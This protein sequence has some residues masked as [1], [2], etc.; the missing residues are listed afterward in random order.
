MI[1]LRKIN[2]RFRG[3]AQPALD[4]VSLE[5]ARGSCC[6]LLGANGAGKTTLILAL[7]GLTPIDSGAI[8]I[9][10]QCLTAR[11]GPRRFW[12]G[13]G[14]SFKQ[15]IGRIGDGFRRP[16]GQQSAGAPLPLLTTI[17]FV[18]QTAAF[19]PT[20]S[21]AENLAFF[22]G[23]RGLRGDERRCEIAR[24][25]AIADLETRLKQRAGTLSGGLQ[26]RLNLAIGLLGR[27]QI[28]CL[29][30]PTVGVDPQSREWL[31][32][33]VEQMIDEGTTVL[34][35]SHYMD[36][37]ARLAHQLVILEQGRVLAAGPYEALLSRLPRRLE[38]HFHAPLPAARLTQLACELG[39][40][41]KLPQQ[42]EWSG[43]LSGEQLRRLGEALVRER[44]LPE[45][46]RL[47]Y[48]T[49]DLSALYFSLTGQGDSAPP[50]ATASA[51]PPTPNRVTAK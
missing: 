25:V 7:L 10:G 47:R 31:L 43:P 27:P 26:R 5:I 33:S 51:S 17:G 19:Y 45:I 18:P 13:L 49:D 50:A 22:A 28:L 11:C 8:Y 15:R 30:E 9:D 4:G 32:N 41:P 35:S 34:Y 24:V 2:K 1:E 16:F 42:I 46:G 36:E 20:L 38:L 3:A 37:I 44:D 14:E 6:G 21:V 12:R 48:A 40:E 29:D 39:G 23:A